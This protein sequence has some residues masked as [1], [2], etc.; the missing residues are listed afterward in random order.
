[1]F[2]VSVTAKRHAK[3]VRQGDIVKKEEL[4]EYLEIL[5]LSRDYLRDGWMRGYDD[6]LPSLPERAERDQTGGERSVSEELA[7]IAREVSACTKCRLAE[8]R[9]LAVPGEGVASPK[10]MIIGEAPGAQEDASGRPFVGPAGR[11]L[12]KW[13]EAIGLSRDRD[14]FIGN[15]IKCRPP[16]NRDPFFDEQQACLPYLERQLDLIRPYAILS[17]GRIS[18]HILTGAEEGI[19][20]LHG[21][22]FTYR[23]IPLIPTY[24]PSGVLRNPQF[25]KPVWEDLKKLKRLIDGGV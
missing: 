5:N 11:Y 19:G 18:T 8:T 13:M 10:V 16:E 20:R 23:G 2:N 17:V 3:L 21:R 6:P 4:S 22:D 24:H 15:I 7:A 1:M 14:I 9:T 12:D 25:R